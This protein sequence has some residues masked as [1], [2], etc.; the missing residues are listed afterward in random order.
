[1]TYDTNVYPILSS[2][3][4]GSDFR[5][6]GTYHSQDG[7]F[8]GSG[9]GLKFDSSNNSVVPISPNGN[10]KVGVDLGSTA[11]KFRNGEFT[12]TVQATDFLDSNGNSIGGV[13]GA[14]DMSTCLLKTGSNQ[15][16]ADTDW[17]VKQEIN[18]SNKTLVHIQDGALG[19]YNLK[20]PTDT[21]HAA[22]KEYVDAQTVKLDLWTYSDGEAVNLADGEFTV[23][24][25]SG[26]I[27]K[28]YMAQK[29]AQ[30]SYYHPALSST[31]Q[32]YH[33][34]VSGDQKGP[35]ITITSKTS[36]CIHFAMPTKAYFNT[37]T[38]KYTRIE[39]KYHRSNYILTVGD[40]YILN[41]PGL[42]TP[43]W[44]W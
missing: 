38:A 12:G 22:T 6:T 33:E 29:N 2:L 40:K 14:A 5:I 30:G 19:V 28:V 34:F 27:L 43:V 24:E 23:R 4:N 39:C 35:P 10:P 9:F 8:V 11:A 32:Y 42:M 17:R 7:N 21:H 20:A 16:P 36:K 25:E 37:G 3:W 1:V 26:G 44:G 41:V 31:D 13:S 18:G 15:L